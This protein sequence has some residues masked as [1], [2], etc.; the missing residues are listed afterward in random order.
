[1]ERN[2]RRD[3]NHRARH[4]WR[5]A[6]DEDADPRETRGS[7]RERNPSHRELMSEWLEG[8]AADGS[9]RRRR[10]GVSTGRAD[11][12]RFSSLR[13]RS[14]VGDAPSPGSPP[15]PAC[16]PPSRSASQESRIL[17]CGDGYWLCADCGALFV[18]REQS[19]SHRGEVE[20]I[21]GESTAVCRLPRDIFTSHKQALS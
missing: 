10:E 18:V 5:S 6:Q 2:D 3:R 11:T 20:I 14:L 21:T 17:S 7:K 15:C 9:H 16:R 8:E 4:H 12:R 1:M 19:D 13:S